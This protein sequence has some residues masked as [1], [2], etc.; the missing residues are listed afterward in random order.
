M[1]EK[2]Y[3]LPVLSLKHEAFVREWFKN[4]FQNKNAYMSV[5]KNVR[6]K[7]AETESSRIL[8]LPQVEHFIASIQSQIRASENIETSYIVKNLK[9]VIEKCK[10]DGDKSNLLK[11]NDQLAKIAGLYNDKP[12]VNVGVAATG[13]VQIS[14][15]GW[16]PTPVAEVSN[17]IND[18]NLSDCDVTDVDEQ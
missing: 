18:D 9:E 11:A 7:T 4:G 14:F 12:S 6:P 13:D 1:E 10:E 3:K 17:Y 8:K 2:E 16:N 15:G 5:Y